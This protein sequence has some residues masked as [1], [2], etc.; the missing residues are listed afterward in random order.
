MRFLCMLACLL[1][2]SL[3]AMAERPVVVELFT[4]QG[5][6]SCPPADDLLIKLAQDPAILALSFHVDY[7]D[8][9]GWKDPYSMPDATQR[10]YAYAQVRGSDQVFTPQAIING[11]GSATGSREMQVKT[12]IESAQRIAASSNVDVSVE[13]HA[14]K[15]SFTVSG[16]D[17]VGAD[18]L[19]VYFIP[20]AETD[21]Q[22]GENSGRKL[23]GVNIVTRIESFG[24]V[25]A[26]AK[27]HELKIPTGGVAV[28]VQQKKHGRIFG[29]ASFINKTL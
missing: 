29:A 28:L 24:T 14:D 2:M 9:L 19:L 17:A 27:S 6:S 3:P 10:Q 1:M 18:I 26:G 13:K 8:R 5:C 22:K 23:R 4:S 12:Q 25:E 20:N 15:L 7:W 11:T 16:S 21:V